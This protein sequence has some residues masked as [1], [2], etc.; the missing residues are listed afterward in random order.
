MSVERSPFL[1]VDESHWLAWN[2][3]AFAIADAYPVTPGH[4][5]VIPRRLIRTWWAAT[6]WE[7]SGMW[8]L[9]DVVKRRRD[10]EY[11]PNGY[12]AG[13]AAGQTVGHFHLHVIPRCTGDV[14]EPR[15][16]IRHIMAGEGTTCSRPSPNLLPLFD[17]QERS[18]RLDLLRCLRGSCSIASTSL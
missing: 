13:P 1:D 7:R 15:G 4:S 5:L 12:N 16:G 11:R 9:V 18:L 8:A 3:V 14:A 17:G 6:E 10:A 2:D